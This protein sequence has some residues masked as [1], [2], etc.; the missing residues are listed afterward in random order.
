ME[1]VDPLAETP[2]WRTNNG[3]I[4]NGLDAEG[5]PIN[6]T[7]GSENSAKIV[8]ESSPRVEITS[9]TPEE[10]MISGVFLV[11]WSATD[12]DGTPEGLRIAIYLS[13][14]GG[15]TWDLL[16]DGLANSGSYAWD[17]ANHRNGES[18]RLRIVATDSDGNSGE[19]ESPPFAIEN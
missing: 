14:D 13:S 6:G 11:G 10:T 15:E 8:V 1:R 18:Y 4:R 9:P 3:L 7:P 17:T 19:A 16:I 5:G 2:A 12:P